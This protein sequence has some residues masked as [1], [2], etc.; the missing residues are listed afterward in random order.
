MGCRNG[1]CQPRTVCNGQAMTLAAYL[2]ERANGLDIHSS[3]RSARQ[4]GDGTGLG[5]DDRPNP[6]R[7]T[8]PD[9][10]AQKAQREIE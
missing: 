1:K 6:Q 4:R 7:P 9:P 3:G 2:K 10:L 5:R 8:G